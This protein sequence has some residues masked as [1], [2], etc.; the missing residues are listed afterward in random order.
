MCLLAQPQKE[1]MLGY[2]ETFIK[3]MENTRNSQNVWDAMHS[4]FPITST[5]AIV[6]NLP[7]GEDDKVIEPSIFSWTETQCL[8]PTKVNGIEDSHFE[9]EGVKQGQDKTKKEL[10]LVAQK[11][12]Q[13]Y[14]KI[15]HI[16]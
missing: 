15:Y 8:D 2:K 5:S 6:S 11:A 13:F 14:E 7:T 10:T 1:I 16:L 12:E 4:K 3:S 9:E